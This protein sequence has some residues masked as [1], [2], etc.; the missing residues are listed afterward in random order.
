MTRMAKLFGWSDDYP[1]KYP[2]YSICPDRRN[3]L[4]RL[5]M[6]AKRRGRMGDYKMG[7]QLIAEKL[8]D[9]RYGKGFYECTDDQQYELYTE[10][11]N[12]YVERRLP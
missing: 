12:Q 2:Q 3:K 5:I 1:H 9:E 11:M 10:A 7:A 6:A 8:A 4:A